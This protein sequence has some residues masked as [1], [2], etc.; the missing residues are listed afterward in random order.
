LVEKPSSTILTL[1]PQLTKRPQKASYQRLASF[2]VKAHRSLGHVCHFG[3]RL[4]DLARLRW[5]N[6]DLEHDELR[7][8]TAKTAKRLIIPL[9]APLSKHIE[10]LPSSDDADSPLPC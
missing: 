10:P 4:G 3:Q 5:S 6:I 9:A 7:L 8:V 1:L 2:D